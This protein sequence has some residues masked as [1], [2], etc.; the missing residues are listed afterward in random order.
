[1][2]DTV[3]LSHPGTQQTW[4]EATQSTDT[5]PLAPYYSGP[6]RVSPAGTQSLEQDAGDQLVTTRTYAVSLPWGTSD[7]LINDVATV[8]ASA[9]PQ[10]AGQVLYVKD[11]PGSAQRTALRLVCTDYA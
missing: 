8:T 2:T 4:N 3:T 5:V 6:A 10:L 1:M 11:A 7:V 9:D